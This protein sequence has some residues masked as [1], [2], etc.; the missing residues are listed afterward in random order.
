MYFAQQ[1]MADALN[2]KMRGHFERSHS[3]KSSL[4]MA[5]EIRFPDGIFDVEIAT[6]KSDRI[7]TWTDSYIII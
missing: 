6:A 5:D 1:Q 7:Y 3:A 2:V 4:G